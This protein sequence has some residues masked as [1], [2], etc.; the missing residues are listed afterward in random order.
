[1]CFGRSGTMVDDRDG[2]WTVIR[3]LRHDG[4]IPPQWTRRDI[5]DALLCSGYSDNSVNTIPSNQSISRDGLVKGNY[6]KNGVPAEAF[7]V[8]PGVFEL[9]DE[10]GSV[11]LST[12]EETIAPQ[13]P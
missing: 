9:I 10:V 12:I 2:F 3:R 11:R 5:R 1:M 6:V 4:K 13:A 8:S 7:R